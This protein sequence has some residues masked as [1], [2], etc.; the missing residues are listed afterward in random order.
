MDSQFANKTL[1]TSFNRAGVR[2]MELELCAHVCKKALNPNPYVVGIRN[3]VSKAYKPRRIVKHH[4]FSRL[5][6]VTY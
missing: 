4:T 1:D 2:T 6:T 5:E 3:E